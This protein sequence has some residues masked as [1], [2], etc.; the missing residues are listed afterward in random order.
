M[1]SLE[2]AAAA[3]PADSMLWSDFDKA[4]AEPE[5]MLGTFADFFGIS[6]APDTLRAIVGGPLL[7]R[8]SKA[9]E[10]E[11]SPALR[12]DLLAQTGREHGAAIG[13]ALGWLASAARGAPLL[14]AALNRAS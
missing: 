10:Y 4:L 1:T 3:M 9:L 6:A 2:R 12:R 7:G 13:E 11:Y 5:R 8:Y 14:E